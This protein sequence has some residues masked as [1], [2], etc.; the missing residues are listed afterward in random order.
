MI[1]PLPMDEIV[2]KGIFQMGMFRT[3]IGNDEIHRHV[4][5]LD[6]QVIV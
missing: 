5:V 2:G 6:L 1:I 4:V 3:S